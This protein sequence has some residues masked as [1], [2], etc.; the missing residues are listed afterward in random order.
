MTN[1]RL[2]LFLEL[3][4]ELVEQHPK[5]I[6]E[7]RRL[8][9]RTVDPATASEEKIWRILWDKPLFANARVKT[10]ERW[11]DSIEAEMD[12]SWET[13]GKD[14]D[15]FYIKYSGSGNRRECFMFKGK[16][17]LDFESRHTIPRHRLFAI[18]G[19]AS[20][21]RSRSGHDR[22]PFADLPGKSLSEIVE[23][24]RVEFDWG[25]GKITVLHALTDMGLAVKPDL[26]LTNTMRHLGLE[27]RDPLEINEHV[28]KLLCA[29]GTSERTDIPNEIRYVDKV[30]MEIS[31]QGLIGTS[32]DWMA[33][34]ISE[35]KRR[36]GRIED[37]LGLSG[38]PAE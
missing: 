10:A 37:S 8:A 26:H 19:A 22:P 3:H 15:V 28:G 17:A 13:W 24:L 1:I 21:L 14:P 30:L 27:S 29:L 6:N 9:K 34:D 16:A 36:L 33:E 25:W 32:S 18:Q 5:S 11:V 12:S 35:I 31:R 38:D 23:M 7:A 2:D 4:D 20:A